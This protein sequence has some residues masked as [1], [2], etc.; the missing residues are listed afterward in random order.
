MNN[1]FIAR[2]P[3]GNDIYKRLIKKS[4][5]LIEP[6]WDKKRSAATAGSSDFKNILECGNL[7]VW[8]CC[9]PLFYYAFYT[10]KMIT[11]NATCNFL[12]L[13]H[14]LCQGIYCQ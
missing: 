3:S 2:S 8:A 10:L 11:L 12:I 7:F 14:K 5:N 4:I 1:F 6:A 13:F 9:I